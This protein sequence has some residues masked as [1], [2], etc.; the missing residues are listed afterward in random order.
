MS[1]E[2]SHP[3]EKKFTLNWLMKREVICSP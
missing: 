1:N 2:A 3:P